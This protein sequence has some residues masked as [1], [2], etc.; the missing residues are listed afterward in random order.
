MIMQ[1]MVDRF[2]Q[3]APVCVMARALLEN[4][5]SPER[6]DAIYSQYDHKQLDGVLLFSTLVEI[7]GLV[8][9]RVQPSVH[10]VY[11]TKVASAEIAV[12]VKA[13]TRA[14]ANPRRRL[15][16]PAATNGRE[17]E[18][19][20]K[21]MGDPPA[22]PLPGYNVR[23]LDGNHMRRTQRRLKV[24]RTVNAAPLPGHSL[25]VLDPQWKLVVDVFPCEDA[26]AQE[27][28]LLPQV[29][30]TVKPNDVWVDDRNFCTLAFLFGIR[31]RKAFFVMREHGNLPFELVGRRSYVGRYE[32]G[33][34]CLRAVDADHRCRRDGRQ[35]SPHH[36]RVG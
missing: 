22:D 16:S 36:D 11:Q 21:K 26:H 10:A 25:V 29:L 12:T 31:A 35:D 8:A 20:C 24:L 34:I 23:I 33:L 14:S 15:A 1:D 17:N 30:E 5:L 13:C 28:S 9:T 6:L 19:H 18:K 32:T 4:V 3:K 27:R 2:K 7:M